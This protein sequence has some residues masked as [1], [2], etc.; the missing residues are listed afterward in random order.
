MCREIKETNIHIKPNECDKAYCEPRTCTPLTCDKAT[1]VDIESALLTQTIEFIM[2][3][4][5]LFE[6][7]SAKHAKLE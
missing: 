4:K 1:C 3:S 6:L 7:I 5:E 2:P